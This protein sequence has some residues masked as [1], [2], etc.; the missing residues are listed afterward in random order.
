MDRRKDLV[1][2]IYGLAPALS[3]LAMGVNIFTHSSIL[4]QDKPAVTEP[5]AQQIVFHSIN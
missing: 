1:I 2:L 3:A 5:A 4:L